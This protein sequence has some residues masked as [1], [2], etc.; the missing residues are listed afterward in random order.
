MMI[1][2]ADAERIAYEF[3]T[4]EALPDCGDKEVA[5]NDAATIEK[6]YGWL[7]VYTTVAFLRSRD[8][9]DALGGSG[10]LLV[11]RENGRVISFSSYHSQESALKAYEEGHHAEGG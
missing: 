8:P 10:P 7:F 6:P 11:L 2:K 1:D 9:A 5:I 3:A 4:R